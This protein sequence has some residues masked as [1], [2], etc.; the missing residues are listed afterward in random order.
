MPKPASKATP[1]LDN[2]TR[3]TLLRS[4][5]R[6]RLGDLREQSL[7]RQGKGWFHISGMGHE[8]LAAI[9]LQMEP[10]DYAFPYYRDRAFCIQRGLSDFDLALAFYAKRESS[11]GG[12]QLTGHFSDRSLNIWSHPSPVGAHLLPACGAAW[13]MQLDGKKN[14]VYAS[15]G[16]ASARQGDFFEAVCFAKER[17]LPVVFVVEDNRIAISTSTTN[18]NPI[19]LGVLN[20]EEWCRVDG[21]DIEA[22]AAAGKKAIEHARAGRGPAFIWC[23]VERFSNHS[24]ADDQRMYR[25]AE[26]LES[27]H[28]RDP[29][30]VYQQSMI[31]DGLLT[32]E[33][34]KAL[35]EEIREEVRAAYQQASTMQDPLAEECALHLTGD[36][37][38]P[39]DMPAIG[40]GDSC[41][42]LDAVNKTFHNVLDTMPD[43]VFFGEDIADPKGGVF[44][45]TKGLSTKDPSRTVNSPLAESTIM[46]VSV[47]L[48]S[49]GKRPCF[50]I[51]FVDFIYPGWNQL[52][53]NMATL[54]WRSF[55]QWKCPLVIYAP[56]GGYLPGGALW[57]SQA[58][59]AS[60]ARV[61]GIRV[62]V[63]STPADAAGLFWTALH[64]QDPTIILL[65]KHLMWAEQPVK[66]V[67]PV[68][69]GRARIVR[70]GSLLTLVTW[71]NCIELVEESLEAMDA[72]LDIELIDLRSIQP[73]DK[74]A[75]AC[76]IQKTGRLLIV[77]EDNIS[78]SVGQMIV[79]EMCGRHNVLQNLKSPPIIVSKEDVHVGFN[80]IYEYAA[81]PDRERIA[82]AIDRLLASTLQSAL[83]KETAYFP[84][85]SNTVHA[86]T[87]IAPEESVPSAATKMI[88]VPILGEGIRV[89]RVVSILKQSGETVR[90]DDPLCEVETDK[91]VFPIECDEDGVLGEWQIAQ[92]D[93][94]KVGQ[95]L[96][97]LMMSGAA[98]RPVMLTS[99][100]TPDAIKRTGGLSQEALKQLQG[101]VPAT[102]DM[103]CR[104]ETVRDA[105]LRS[106]KTPGGT[107]STATM[108]AWAVLQAMKK[109]ERF[110]SVVRGNELV[111][112]PDRLDLGVAVALPGDALETAV[113]KNAQKL[114]WESFQDV[115]NEALRSTRRG[116]VE[117]KNR[118]S[119]TISSMGAYNVRSAIPIVVPPSIATLFIGAPYQLPDP[120]SENGGTMEV[121]SLV[122]TF[123]HRWINGVGAAAFLSD[124][125][126]GI[127]RF[128]LT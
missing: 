7:I 46:G 73:W 69:L 93:E 4:L 30:A 65:P 108:T 60:F 51:Q 21:S 17:M 109:H 6:S 40:L 29:I 67:T 120:K 123:D 110:A 104:W 57:H 116:E 35:E 48:A 103:T 8:A 23:D 105:R 59:E 3:S 97:A 102:I 122:L 68:P 10:E 45:L 13:G 124:V 70:E 2:M 43:V 82:A 44:N 22:V 112:D 26:E 101:I 61:P 53:S 55:G 86:A 32:T 96:I 54:R 91:A 126:K 80:P 42:M 90:A 99:P 50:E 14:V 33:G 11:S 16:E 128:D 81:L 74:E 34:A 113:V 95:D 114:D 28:L 38:T 121:A 83:E 100:E 76:S 52:V 64:G 27:I 127:E 77:Q 36:P 20:E 18:T 118:V 47:G 19:A 31:E 12:R 89:A 87:M 98:P 125:R 119:L 85:V 41:R 1:L 107:L 39:G 49:Y 111:Y 62:A 25:A 5:W 84:S 71:G 72:E 78:A 79:A 58:S 115:F 37:S 92:D 63:P 106:K 66:D 56:C 15:L 24:S 94:V 88:T 117:S 75:I 9:A